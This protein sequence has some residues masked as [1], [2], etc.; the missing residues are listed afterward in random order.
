MYVYVRLC[1]VLHSDTCVVIRL[2]LVL[3]QDRCCWKHIFCRHPLT[4]VKT[5]C[6]FIAPCRCLAVSAFPDFC[7]CLC[8]CESLC[9]SVS[10]SQCPCVPVSRSVV[11]SIM[12]PIRPPS[13]P[14]PCP[15][16]PNRDARKHTMHAGSL[17]LCLELLDKEQLVCK[18][19]ENE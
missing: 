14:G 1:L 8:V 7:V 13:P 11:P 15:S 3:L 5:V 17:R 19:S 12:K 2:H 6:V 10:L 4:A 16:T 9:L 18:K